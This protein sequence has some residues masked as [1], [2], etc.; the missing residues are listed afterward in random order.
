MASP[1]DPNIA[2]GKI[3]HAKSFSPRGLDVDDSSAIPAV[4]MA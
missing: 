3:I 2:T 1:S 4:A